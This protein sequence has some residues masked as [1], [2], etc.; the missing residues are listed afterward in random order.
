MSDADKDK[1]AARAAVLDAFTEAGR[2]DHADLD[3]A[4]FIPP[5]PPPSDTVVEKSR[6]TWNRAAE[7]AKEWQSVDAGYFPTEEVHDADAILFEPNPRLASNPANTARAEWLK[8][9][10]E[11]EEYRSLHDATMLNPALSALGAKSLCDQWKEY[12]VQASDDT[13][14]IDSSFD[15]IRSTSSALAKAREAVSAG[16]DAMD[17]FGLGG[18][19]SLG[20][21]GCDMATLSDLFR[22]MRSDDTLRKILA[23]SGRMIRLCRG[24][25]R[26]KQ[27]HGCDEIVGVTQ[28]GALD[29]VLTSELIALCGEPDLQLL[30]LLTMYRLVQK[31]LLCRH[32]RAM[33]PVGKGPIVIVV[34][35]SGSMSGDK[36][37]TAKALAMALAWLAR[38]QNRWCGLVGFAGGTEGHTHVI[39]PVGD[40]SPVKMVEW[41]E[42]FYSGGNDL[43]VPLKELPEVYWP[44]FV[45]SG[46]RRGDTDVVMITDAIVHAPAKMVADYRLWAASE[47]VTTRAIIIGERSAGDLTQVCQQ[48]WF[49]HEFKPDKALDSESVTGLLSL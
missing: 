20:N 10:M 22:K 43:D 48:I 46:L 36:I 2:P 39:P 47:R 8:Q 21:A 18:D 7:I 33:E 27:R 26:K 9:L 14:S 19:G 31:S 45:E 6:W 16:R 44:A 13:E 15:R 25:Q 42:H 35:E 37:I 4:E 1:Q 30:E 38:N 40:K 12:A 28:G 32:R 3:G 41:L 23:L 5:P 24:L 17:A 11:T 29:S 34:D 49:E